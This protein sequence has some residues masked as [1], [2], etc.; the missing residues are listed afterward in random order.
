MTQ[1]NPTIFDAYELGS[2]LDKEEY[3]NQLSSLRVELVNYQ[4]QLRALKPSLLI[5]LTGNDRKSVNEFV[6]VL[7]EWMDAR[8]L[9]THVYLPRTEYEKDYPSYWRYWQKLPPAGRIG[10]F[11]GAWPMQALRERLTPN[12]SKEVLSRRIR[13]IQALEKTLVDNG[14][15]VLKFW[16][17]LPKD[18]VKK[19]LKKAKKNPGSEPYIRQED[20]KVY[21]QYEEIIPVAERLVKE[22][23]T[24]DAPWHVVEATDKRYRNMFMAQKIL[25]TL[26]NLVEVGVTK[27]TPN[28]VTPALG[29]GVGALSLM[30]L[31]ARLDKIDYKT[32]LKLLQAE[33]NHLIVAAR[34]KFSTVLLFEGWD[35]AGKGGVIR[36]ITQALFAEDYHVIPIAAPS[37]EEKKYHYLWRFWRRLPGKGRVAIFDRSWYGRVLV[38]RVEGFAKPE[39]WQRAYFEINDFEDQLIAHNMVVCKF[40]LQIDPEEQLKRFKEREELAYKNHKITEEDYRNRNNWE[41]YTE[42]VNDMIARTSTSTAPWH[43]ISANNKRWAR[44][45]V[46]KIVVNQLKKQMEKYE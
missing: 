23:S 45:E 37:E 5:L 10:C 42:S 2:T 34:D 35:A 22:T 27:N 17:H 43:L 32:Q 12:G 29:G 21:E 18:E 44:I 31:S 1:E 28:V 36:R 20:W 39:E 15:V 16:L 26:K 19:Q 38:E 14:T 6:D 11:L 33:L 8:Y 25:A 4:Y 7:H 41:A 24:T 46:L 9:H 30:D 13:H 3:D 40:W